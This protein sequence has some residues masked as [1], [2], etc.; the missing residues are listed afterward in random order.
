[1]TINSNL[2][3]SNAAEPTAGINYAEAKMWFGG[4]CAVTLTGVFDGATVE[5]IATTRLLTAAELDAGPPYDSVLADSEWVSLE[6]LTAPGV[7]QSTLNPCLLAVRITSPGAST[8][9]KALIS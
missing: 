7:Y 5:V 2:L 9:V 1:M 6:S 8:R 3:L 4:P